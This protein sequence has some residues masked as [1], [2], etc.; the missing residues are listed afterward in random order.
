MTTI[1]PITVDPYAKQ[2]RKATVGAAAF[3]LH[4]TA[5]VYLRP[6]ERT[7]VPTG[8]RM[9]LPAG[10][11]AWVLSRSGLAIKHGVIVLNSPGLVDPDYRGEIGVELY[12]TDKTEVFCAE[13]DDRIAQLYIPTLPDAE[14]QVVEKLDTT[15]RGE[16]GFG[17]TGIKAVA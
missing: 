3:D 16:Q 1:I 17:S 5:T 13:P 15:S 9:A 12:N 10:H 11:P 7:L 8:L 2:P 14:L 6:G 4:T